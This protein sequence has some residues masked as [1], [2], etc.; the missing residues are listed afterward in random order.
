MLTYE[1]VLEIFADYLKEDPCAEV[2]L[3]SRCYAVMVWDVTAHDWESAI[4]C[5]TP[6][7]LF[8]ALLEEYDK[9]QSF[10]MATA[11]GMEEY[12]PEIRARVDAMCGKLLERRREKELSR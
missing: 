9:F 1:N 4:P 12:T 7:K 5:E 8:D 2:V 3:T 10:Q 6:D 11:Q